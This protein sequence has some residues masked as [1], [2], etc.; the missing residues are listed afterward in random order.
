MLVRLRRYVIR[1]R[2]QKAVAEFDRRI[3]EARANHQPVAH[4][5]RARQEYVHTLLAGAVSAGIK[6]RAA[7]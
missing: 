3:E 1:K 2:F 4:L 6:A 5:I 7:R